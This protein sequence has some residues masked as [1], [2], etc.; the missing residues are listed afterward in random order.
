MSQPLT[1]VWICERAIREMVRDA[2]LKLPYETGGILLGYFAGENA[3]VTEI[4]GPGPKAIHRKMSFIP[5]YDFHTSSIAK[6]YDRSG[7]MHVYLGEWHTHPA[8][9][10]R[11]SRKDRSTLENIVNYKEA[12]LSTPLMFLLAGD[13]DWKL[14]AWVCYLHRRFGLTMAKINDIEIRTYR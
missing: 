11:L 3:V 5:D 14:A 9:A 6:S 2:N 1:R 7:R 12:R 10:L 4:V 8:G 13:S